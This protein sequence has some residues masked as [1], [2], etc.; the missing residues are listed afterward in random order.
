MNRFL[1]TIACLV[2]TAFA[3]EPLRDGVFEVHYREADAEL[4]RESLAI[5]VQAREEFAERLP[6]GDEPVHVAIAHT[7]G[8]FAQFAGPYAIPTVT[9]VAIPNDGIIAVK[10]PDLLPP[11]PI[12][13]RG[14]LRH[15]L[16]HV[17]L[18]RN[19][20][21]DNLPRWFNE[22]I[23]MILSGEHRWESRWFVAQMYARGQLIRYDDLRFA[24]GAPGK[25]FE[26]GSAYAQALSMTRY[27]RG[28]LGEE[29][30]WEL[31]RDLESTPFEEALQQHAD[32]TPA[33][34]M[35]AWQATLWNIAALSS[36][37]SGVTVFQ[38]GALLTVMAYVRKRRSRKATLREWAEQEA[39]DEGPPARV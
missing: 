30:F 35:E 19:V 9:G 12:D 20:D 27:L 6:I 11:G 16:V 3:Q 17:L 38:V 21:T 8:E 26:F 18:A 7:R 39:L 36:L 33:K 2:V 22:G 4:A 14:T 28:E 34:L 32:L 1:L 29:R 25:E 5:L 15:E 24:F 37:V 10:I 13:Y 23:A 31:V